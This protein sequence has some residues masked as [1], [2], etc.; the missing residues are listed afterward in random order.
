MASITGIIR[1][2]NNT[3]LENVTVLI[4]SGPSH[5]DVA[6]MTRADGQFSM[7]SLQTGDYVLKAVGQVESEEIAVQVLSEQIPFI[8][9]WLESEVT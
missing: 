5:H 8:E 2:T 1:D 4:V 7:R 9:I 6:A 3:P